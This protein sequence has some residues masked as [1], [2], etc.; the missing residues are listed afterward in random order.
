MILSHVV[1][2]HYYSQVTVLSVAATRLVSLDWCQCQSKCL[3]LTIELVWIS[4][5]VSLV[6]LF[7]HH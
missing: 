5:F 7:S 3:I 1:F 2:Q 6:A 4:V